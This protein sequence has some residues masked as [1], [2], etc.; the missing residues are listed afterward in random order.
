MQKSRWW[1][2]FGGRSSQCRG[3]QAEPHLAVQAEAAWL[4]V[5]RRRGEMMLEKAWDQSML[6]GRSKLGYM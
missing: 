2:V 6:G 4:C 3:L 1:K 5:E